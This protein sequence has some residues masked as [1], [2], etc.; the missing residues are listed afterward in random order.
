MTNVRVRNFNQQRCLVKSFRV[1]KEK[2]T[3]LFSSKRFSSSRVGSRSEMP[4]SS[5]QFALDTRQ[6]DAEDGQNISTCS[7][8]PNDFPMCTFKSRQIPKFTTPKLENL[9]AEM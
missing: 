7:N 2:I 6:K 9:S 5:I 1:W 8:I 4:R 3:K